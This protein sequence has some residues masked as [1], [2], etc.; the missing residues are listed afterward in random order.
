VGGVKETRLFH[1]GEVDDAISRGAKESG[2]VEPSL[3]IPKHAPDENGTVR[4]LNSC[5][6]AAGLKKPDVGRSNQ[7]TLPIIAQKNKIIRAKYIILFFHVEVA[8]SIGHKRIEDLIFGRGS[9]SICK[10]AKM[11]RNALA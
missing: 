7:P 11:G 3:A 4:E 10:F 8:R 1:V 5:L 2:G 6:I 9:L